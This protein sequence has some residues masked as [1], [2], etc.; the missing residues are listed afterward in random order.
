MNN[1]SLVEEDKNLAR[2]G[3]LLANVHFPSR[4][5]A[6]IYDTEIA[7]MLINRPILFIHLLIPDH[8]FFP[9]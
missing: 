9:P 8:F 6:T 2:L 7:S 1:A 4:D 3:F 5:L